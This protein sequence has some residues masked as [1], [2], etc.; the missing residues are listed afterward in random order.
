MSQADRYKTEKELFVSDTTGSSIHH[1]NAISLVALTSVALYAVLSTRFPNQPRGFL[2][3][4][5]LLVLP[6]LLSM[7]LFATAPLSLSALIAIPAAL[8]LWFPRRD[9]TSPLPSKSPPSTP[10]SGTRTPRFPSMISLTVY[11]A[12]MM[13]MT[14]LAI[15]AVDFPVFPRMLAKC[16]TF[17]ISL[18]DLGVGS[19]VFSQGLVSAI[20]FISQPSYLLEPITAKLIKTVRKSIPIL[21]LGLIRVLLVKGTDYPEHVTEYGVHWNFFLTLALLP[22]LQVILHPI[23]AKY[24]ISLISLIVAF[25]QH[26]LL[27]QLNLQSYILS[28]PRTNLFSANKEGLISLLGYLS[29]HLLGLSAGTIIL[30]HSP[31][32]FRRHQKAISAFLQIQDKDKVSRFVGQGTEVGW[33]QV[34]KTAQEV[35]S[36]TFVWWVGVGVCWGLGVGGTWVGGEGGV[37]RRMVNLPYILW[38]AA[39]N[40]SF[41]LGYLLLLDILFFPQLTPNKKQLQNGVE[42]P[43]TSGRDNTPPLFKAINK[44]SLTVFLFANLMTG[45]INLAIPTMYTQDTRAML[46]LSAYSILVCA[47]AWKLDRWGKSIT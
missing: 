13:L 14:I 42:P 47:I 8:L 19:F 15:L 36:Y 45:G 3:Q 1:V 16:E 37:S 2:I 24:P 17:G 29:I 7:T 10:S 44:H 28:A 46:V 38:V 40:T 41:F 18:M 9:V 20:P 27:T 30:P 25:A 39:F 12:H 4:W 43:P 34:G 32:Y 35:F 31:S 26:L 22:I 21:V 33:R 5:A 6:L 11:R 23:L